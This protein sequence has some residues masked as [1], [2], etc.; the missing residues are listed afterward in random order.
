[1][2]LNII[3]LLLIA[4]LGITVF[5][6]IAQ[7]N[8]NVPKTDMEIEKL[9]I[10]LQTVENE[11][12]EVETK[13]AEANTKLINT[14]I[15]KLKGEL[16]ESNNNWLKTWNNWFIGIVTF[17]VLISGAALLLVL[18]TL[19]ENGIEK[20][21]DGFKDAVDKVYIIEDQ[22]RLLRKE[23]TASKI[24][25]TFQP[26]FGS[27]LG[28]PRENETRREEAL[29]EILEETL[30]DVFGDKKYHSGIRHKAAKVLAQKLPPVVDPLFSQLNS[31]IDPESDIISKI[32]KGTL[33]DSIAILRGI[34]NLEVYD[35]LTKYLNRLLLLENIELKDSFLTFTFFS[36]LYVG[37]AL[38]TGNSISKMKEAIPHLKIQEIKTQNI[39][40]LARYF[41]KF[42]E[43]EGIKEIYN[44]H[45][46]GK[47]PALEET[48]LNLLK[49]KYPDFV[50][51]QREEK[52]STNTESE[53]SDESEPT[54]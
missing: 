28:L 5:T 24:E 30:L 7:Q 44:V 35:W 1:M 33:R 46:K 20:R 39:E 10:Q 31:A 16:R 2:K 38:D 48:C 3:Y 21:L 17:I 45:A 18:K 25:A 19:I 32:G 52:A 11:K 6:S 26:D 49:K 13:L 27:G 40:D 41:D 9:K 43:Y 47:M 4:L 29:K 34:G 23:Q 8:Q 54:E 37:N 51:E 14:D 15:D 12:M 53:E 50:R 36:L 42:G 22:L